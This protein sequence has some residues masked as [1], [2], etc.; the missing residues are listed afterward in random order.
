MSRGR[1]GGRAR[2]ISLLERLVEAQTV[3]LDGLDELIVVGLPDSFSGYFPL[4]IPRHGKDVDSSVG[5]QT[6]AEV[7]SA[8]LRPRE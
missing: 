3:R 4:I 6:S 7:H 1:R 5:V 8:A 2:L